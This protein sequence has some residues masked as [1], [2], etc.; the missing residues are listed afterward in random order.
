M[1]HLEP[2]IPGYP[3]HI[4][5]DGK[6]YRLN[7]FFSKN[8]NTYSKPSKPKWI[9]IKFKVIK[10]RLKANLHDGHG[11][12]KKFGLHQLLAIA[13]IPNPDNLPCVC[14]RDD[15]KFNNNLD[16]LYWG[17]YKDNTMDCR[18]NGKF[19]ELPKVPWNKFSNEKVEQ[20]IRFVKAN[21]NHTIGW[22]LE[23]LSICKS[24][25]YRILRKYL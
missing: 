4:T 9:E 17:T 12:R 8:G 23:K 2:N 14:H 3:Y 21:P 1:K 13:Y 10:G 22:Y 25:F 18:N 20:M 16:N 7:L 19:H 15:D 5:K 6:L 24:F 11:N